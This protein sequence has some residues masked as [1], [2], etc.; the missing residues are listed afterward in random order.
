MFVDP[1]GD[2]R[3]RPLYQYLQAVN[4]W[5][6]Y[7]KFLGL[8]A[9]RADGQDRDVPLRSLFVEPA[10][11]SQHVSA[12]AFSAGSPPPPTQPLSALFAASDRLVILGDP[13]SG[14][15]TIVNW[16]C[17]S[18]SFPTSTP[19][20][21]KHGALIPLPMVLRELQITADV[22]WESLLEAFLARPVAEALREDLRV[23]DRLLGMGQA[24]ILIDGVDEIGSLEVREALRR[25]VYAGMG[26]HPLCRW[27]ITSRIVGY[28]EVPFHRASEDMWLP[29]ASGA[30]MTLLTIDFVEQLEDFATV[31]Y[32]APFD[33]ERIRQYAG[34]WW[35]QHT[36]NPHLHETSPREFFDRLVENGSTL[37]LARNPNILTLILLIYRKL[38]DLPDGRAKLYRLIAAAY[39]EN[40]DAAYEK[41][42]RVRIRPL[43]Y[44]WEKMAG[45]LGAVAWELQRRRGEVEEDRVRKDKPR[46]QREI[47]LKKT[48]LQELLEK[49]IEPQGTENV[50]AVAETFIQY[51]ARRSG[52]LLPRGQDADGQDLYAFQHLSFQEYFASQYL[53]DAMSDDAWRDLREDNVKRGTTLENFR[54]YAASRPWQETLI[55]LWESAEITSQMFPQRLMERLMGWAPGTDPEG[56]KMLF[57]SAE[58][59]RRAHRSAIGFSETAE[60]LALVAV[61]PHVGLKPAYRRA[62]WKRLWEWEWRRQQEAH[63]NERGLANRSPVASALLS[64]HWCV[65]EISALIARGVK[66]QPGDGELWLDGGT[67]LRSLEPL[68]SLHHLWSL[69]LRD[70]PRIFDLT[71]LRALTKLRTLNLAGCLAL[72]EYAGL[73]PL[74]ELERL[75]LNGCSGLEKIH[76]LEAHPTLQLLS[77][78]GCT[79]LAEL[80]PLKSLA[81]LR[82]LTLHGCKKLTKLPSFEGLAQLESLDLEGCT[83][84]TELPP[85]K[86]LAQLRDLDLKGCTGLKELPSWKNL[87]RLEDLILNDCAGLTCLPP[88]E[89]LAQLEYLDLSR[90]TGLAAVPSLKGLDQLGDVYFDGCTGLTRLPSLEGLAELTFLSLSDCTGLTELSLLEDLPNL[91]YLNLTG[92]SGLSPG[93]RQRLREALP[94][95]EIVDE[96]TE[97]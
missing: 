86:D 9:F 57:V 84:L 6:G 16:I 37:T 58:K 23:L 91:S 50:S 41:N 5:H 32:V 24:V 7:M 69:S 29:R 36:Q 15:T 20:R 14:K 17:D 19:L 95:V 47:L 12:E 49:A 60:L 65:E 35:Q 90:C 13:G 43:A 87:A 53:R 42:A 27:I 8:E 31:A 40:I 30:P 67:A 25:A 82:Q 93:Y 70:G 68:A 74:Q 10:L 28:D 83:G 18:F 79:S 66:E 44:P 48:E 22:T 63:K 80:P 92:C 88:L 2:R 45:W 1:F 46:S 52:L 38:L 75:Y 33:N 56:L 71:P 59:W 26:K 34:L 72:T 21:E 97:P 94:H 51:A 73:E 64:R 4:A 61:N 11:V 55:F 77:L 76:S 39:L 96:E 85:L 78:R 54:A 3:Y 89:D 81:H 62:W